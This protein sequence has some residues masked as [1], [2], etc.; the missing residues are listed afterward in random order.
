M[1]VNSKQKTLAKTEG[2][3]KN[4]QSNENTRHRTKTNKTQKT[5]RRKLKRLAT[6]NPSKTGGEPMCTR[7]ASSSRVL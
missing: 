2:T 7:R 4:G 1:K 6:Q 5:Q 3:L